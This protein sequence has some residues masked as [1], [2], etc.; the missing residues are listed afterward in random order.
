M[1][2]GVL[3]SG[4]KVTQTRHGDDAR[5]IGPPAGVVRGAEP[6]ERKAAER[7]ELVRQVVSRR[8]LPAVQPF[9]P[10]G[11]VREHRY[12]VLGRKSADI[13]VMGQLVVATEGVKGR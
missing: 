6:V 12:P 1:I 7:V 13:A 8:R 10:G 9:S 5:R 4:R 3:I 2:G 11:Q